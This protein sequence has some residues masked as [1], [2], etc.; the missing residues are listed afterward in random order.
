ML[1]LRPGLK[2][3]VESVGEILDIQVAMIILP[4]SSIMEELACAVKMIVR[5]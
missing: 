4:Y 3:L 5:E 2:L 1:L